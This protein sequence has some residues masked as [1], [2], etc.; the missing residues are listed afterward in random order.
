NYLD[1]RTMAISFDGMAAYGGR[2]FTLTGV[3]RPETVR[4]VVVGGDFF[5]IVRAQPRLGRLFTDSD[6]KPD[7]RVAVISYGFWRSHFGMSANVIG[8]KMVLEGEPYTV[9][10]VVAENLRYDAWRPS[11]ADILLPLAWDEKNRAERKN[12]NY[13]VVSRLKPGV[14]LPQA[15]AEM[16]TI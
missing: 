1:W 13:L 4:G 7:S 12:H 8:Q 10:G 3:D 2:Q 11:A 16:N 9:I 15:Q 14:S 5:S 6:D